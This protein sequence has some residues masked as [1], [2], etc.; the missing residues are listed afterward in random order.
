LVE[1]VRAVQEFLEGSLHR[2]LRFALTSPCLEAS[3]GGRQIKT[4]LEKAGVRTEEVS[5]Q[6]LERAS[7]TE[8]HQGIALVV[9]EEVM[10]FPPAAE[11]HFE[12]VLLLDGIQDPGNAGTLIRAGRAFGLSRVIALEGT[13]DLLNPKVVRASAGALACLPVHRRPWNETRAWLDEGGISLLV[14]RAG[15]RD[16]RT[17]SPPPAWALAVG[18]EGAGVRSE[19]QEAASEVVGIPMVSGTDSL[20]AGVAGAILMFAL[21]PFS[22]RRTET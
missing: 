2:D 22:G 3:E 9:R 14:G 13:V 12:R 18:N 11:T 16:V 19:I 5:D 15:G 1:G 17:L 7:D 8:N 21:D 4:R 6:E 10:A 20:N